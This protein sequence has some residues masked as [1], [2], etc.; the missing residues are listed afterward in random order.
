MEDMQNVTFERPRAAE[1]LRAE[2]C[3]G[4]M[5]VFRDIVA[6]ELNNIPPKSP[7]GAS[8]ALTMSSLSCLMLWASTVLV[9][10][11]ASQFFTAAG[12]AMLTARRYWKGPG[13]AP[14]GGVAS[15]RLR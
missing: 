1:G 12:C 15:L 7:L 4:W 3:R 6:P 8:T 9:R 11:C 5:V 2:C 13:R 10:C 14:V